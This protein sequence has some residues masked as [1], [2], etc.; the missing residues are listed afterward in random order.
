MFETF[1]P[2]NPSDRVYVQKMLQIVTVR[3]GTTHG[4]VV[5]LSLICSLQ[6]TE[7]S[8]QE[9]AAED[10]GECSIIFLHNFDHLIKDSIP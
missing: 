7:L 9:P 3:A 4:Q 5:I 8:S 1:C 6:S 10:T 2:D